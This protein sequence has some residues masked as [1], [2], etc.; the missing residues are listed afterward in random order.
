MTVAGHWVSSSGGFDKDFGPHQARF[1]VH[2][3]HLADG[4]AHFVLAEPGS[5]APGHGFV[6]NFEDGRKEEI[7]SGPTTRSENFGWHK[8]C[9]KFTGHYAPVTDERAANGYP[10]AAAMVHKFSVASPEVK[11]QRNREAPGE[12]ETSRLLVS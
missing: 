9:A 10:A 11:H 8:R 5:F 7:A 3:S 2:R 12:G 1:D 6:T 4:N